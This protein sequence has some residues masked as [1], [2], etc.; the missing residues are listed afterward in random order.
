MHGQ[1]NLV[2]VWDNTPIHESN[3]AKEFYLKNEI[4]RIEWPS[5]STDFIST[6]E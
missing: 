4:K 2:L 3:K 6:R 5:R 1:Q